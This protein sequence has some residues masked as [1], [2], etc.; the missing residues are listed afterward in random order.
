ME[1]EVGMEVEMVEGMVVSTYPLNP[2]P[3]IFIVEKPPDFCRK[4]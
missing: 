1:A 3:R 2:Y 4:E